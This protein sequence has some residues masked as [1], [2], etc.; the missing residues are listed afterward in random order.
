[1]SQ[2]TTDTTMLK[3]RAVINP[4]T[5]K[6]GIRKEASSTNSA[7]ITNINSPKVR[8]VIGS[9]SKIRSGLTN[10]FRIPKTTATSTTVTQLLT[11]TPGIIYA[12]AI[13]AIQ[14]TSR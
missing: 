6:P 13:T 8:M 12:A 9:V 2:E 4:L 7:L 14:L 5:K 10:E 3:R 1:M 11:T